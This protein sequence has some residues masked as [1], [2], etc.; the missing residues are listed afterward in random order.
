[1]SA[2]EPAESSAAKPS[3]ASRPAGGDAA[4]APRRISEVGIQVAGIALLLVILLFVT[5]SRN[6]NI[7]GAYN[8]QTLSRDIAILSLFAMGQGIIIL[9]GGIDLSVGSVVCFVG[10]NVIFFLAPE[11]GRSWPLALVL[12]MALAFGAGLG[13]IHGILTCQLRLQP[14]MVTL[15]SLLIFRSI[16]R[17]IT[18]D[19]TVSFRG[20]DL[21]AFDFLGNGVLLGVP[22]PVWTLLVVASGLI[23]FL[24]GTVHGRYLFAIGYNLEAARFSGVRVHGLRVFTFALGGFLAALA[25][26]LEASNIHSVSPSTAGMAYELHGIT[27]AVLGGC[28]LRGGQGSIL[29]IIIGAAILKVLQRMIVFLE[30][31]THWTDAVIGMVLLSAVVLDSVVKRRKGY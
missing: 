29:G 25:G 18:G 3:G 23:F 28:A 27:A 8:L 30:L 31:E 2:G 7:L 16:A 11:Y 26:I 4:R 13:A 22:F 20:G 17:G 12:P 21:P 14:F 19:Y 5:W 1:M 10:L 9:A 6:P 15:C 24:H